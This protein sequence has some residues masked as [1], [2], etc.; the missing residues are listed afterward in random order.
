[1][2]VDGPLTHHRQD[3]DIRHRWLAVPRR[4][5]PRVCDPDTFRGQTAVMLDEL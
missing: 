1:M 2:T 5:V 3:G 4:W